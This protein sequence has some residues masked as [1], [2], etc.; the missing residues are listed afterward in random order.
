M[1]RESPPDRLAIPTK[2]SVAFAPPAG[3]E[4]DAEETAPELGGAAVPLAEQA[5]TASRNDA[6]APR[7]R[8]V[9]I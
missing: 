6:A 9:R 7:T 1:V 8:P 2:E 3:V 4:P 5:L